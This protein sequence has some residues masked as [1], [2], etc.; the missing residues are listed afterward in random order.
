MLVQNQCC[1][2]ITDQLLYSRYMPARLRFLKLLLLVG[3]CG[4]VYDK[5]IPYRQCSL[6]DQLFQNSIGMRSVQHHY[7][8]ACFARP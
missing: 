4:G 7:C 5:T 6:A 2:V 1:H 8:A 3:N